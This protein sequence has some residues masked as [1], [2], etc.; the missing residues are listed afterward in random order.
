MCVGGG[1][2]LL[3]L[4]FHSVT[5]KSER[6]RGGS[7][8]QDLSGPSQ[9]LLEDPTKGTKT[10]RRGS[11]GPWAMALLCYNKGCGQKFEADDNGDGEISPHPDPRE[12]VASAA[13]A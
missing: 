13:L 7:F 4:L 11:P 6:E 3:F 8:S 10:L 9:N 1:G 2:G 5:A 12:H